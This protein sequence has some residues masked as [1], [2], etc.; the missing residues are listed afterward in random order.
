MY[1]RSIDGAKSRADNPE[2]AKDCGGTTDCGTLTVKGR[3]R[4]GG[5]Q[6]ERGQQSEEE[7]ERK[8]K[9]GRKEQDEEMIQMFNKTVYSKTILVEVA[10]TETVGE[11]KWTIR[12]NTMCADDVVCVVFTGRIA[13]LATKAQCM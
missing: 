6:G 5:E 4:K 11:I 2:D 13:E 10:P 1:G 7:G 12:R 3:R 9:R 8:S